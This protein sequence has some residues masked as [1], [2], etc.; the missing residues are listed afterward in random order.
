MMIKKYSEFISESHSDI[1][2]DLISYFDSNKNEILKKGLDFY[3]LRNKFA[4]S[5]DALNPFFLQKVK[6][7]LSNIDTSNKELFK[8][9]FENV[10]LEITEELRKTTITESFFSTISSIWSEIK[11]HIKNAVKWISDRIWSI[12]GIITIG[13]AGALFIVNQWGSGIGIP[14]EFGNVLI[15]T[16]LLIGIAVLKFGQKNDEYKNISEI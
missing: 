10:L 7:D 13:L 4:Q 2:S 9:T 1:K 5:I 6:D 16:V 14:T 12:T 3:E 15:N 11:N 8:S